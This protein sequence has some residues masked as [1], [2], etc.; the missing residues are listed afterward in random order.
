MGEAGFDWVYYELRGQI[1][2]SV[3]SGE[4]GGRRRRGEGGGEGRR[5]GAGRGGERERH[6]G[7]AGFDW[8]YYELRGQIHCSVKSGETGGRRRRGE[9]GGEGRREGAGRGGEGSGR[10]GEAG[11]DWVYYELR[12]QIHC[13]VKSGE[14]GGRRRRGEGGG[15]GRRE[16]A[17]RGGEGS[18][19]MGEAGFD[20][21]YYEL[22]GQIHCSVKSGETGGR[23]RRGEGGGEGRREGAGRGGEG[24]GRMGEAGFDWVYY[25]L[26]GQIHC[27]VKSGEMN[28]RDEWRGGVRVG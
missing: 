9:G 12:G 21:V 3:K 25:E 6:I 26:R 11:F 4:T 28:G 7:E 19:R 27:S 16:G 17:G 1:H 20:W 8:V 24:S 14:T 18:G 5:E 13:S 10:M 22:R 2:C 23:R 15:E